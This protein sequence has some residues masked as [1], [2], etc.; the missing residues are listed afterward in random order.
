MA[1]GLLS[2]A[3]IEEIITMD[4]RSVT[5]RLVAALVFGAAIGVERQWRQ[6]LAGVRTNALVALGS[7]MFVLLSPASP[8]GII[9]ERTSPA[10]APPAGSG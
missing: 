6:R 4:A 9:L 1:C 5:L 8:Q 10:L 7:A 3:A 2:V